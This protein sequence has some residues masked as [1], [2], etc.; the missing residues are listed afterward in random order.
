MSDEKCVDCP[1]AIKVL[2]LVRRVDK[3]EDRQDKIDEKMDV[4]TK[5]TSASISSLKESHAETKAYAKA[6]LEQISDLKSLFKNN[7]ESNLN[8][9][10]KMD[11]T[12]ANALVVNNKTNLE[13]NKATQEITRDIEVN[14]NNNKIELTKTKLGVIAGAITAVVTIVSLLIDKFL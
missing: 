13:A 4:H 1:P 12:N 10:L 3:L 8:L 14:H 2:E 11:E 7:N 5:E 9:I 6:T